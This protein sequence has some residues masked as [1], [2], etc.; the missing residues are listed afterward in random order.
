MARVEITGGW[1]SRA[2]AVDDTWLE[3]EPRRR[4][5]A[6][7]L[8]TESRLMPWLAPQLPLPVPVP[9]V[10]RTEPLMVRHRLLPGDSRTQLTDGAGAALGRF[11]RCLHAVDV[12]AAVAVGVPDARSSHLA[13]CRL[14][15]RFRAD[16]LPRVPPPLRDA[17]AELLGRLSRPAPT[18]ALVH[19]DVGP[20]HILL[21][22][23]VVSGVIDWTDAHIGDPAM[24]LAWLMHGSGAAEAV[25][26][27]YDAD[28]DLL[29]RARDWHLLGPWHE[30]TYGLDTA[31]P[32]LVA[33]G[34][35]GVV[36]RLGAG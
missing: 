17:G 18:T 13:L 16:V 33:S 36:S 10:V 34:T 3:R 1:D 27:G 14:L 26:R 35:G 2:F 11:F 31:R 4:E 22:G 19:G 5:V 32:D 24:D 8:L 7:R 25:A 6:E 15:D 30:V 23:G 29:A 12:D 28:P 9:E 21:R 20:A